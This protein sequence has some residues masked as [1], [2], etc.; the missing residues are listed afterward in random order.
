M[1]TQSIK[2][3]INSIF[4]IF[5]RI[6]GRIYSL[7]SVR[8]NINNIKNNLH[9]IT[10]ISDFS[11]IFSEGANTTVR[12]PKKIL[13]KCCSNLGVKTSRVH[14][15][16]NRSLQK[17]KYFRTNKAITFSQ[18]LKKCNKENYEEAEVILRHINSL[19]FGNRANIIVNKKY[20]VVPNDSLACRNEGKIY[21]FAQGSCVVIGLQTKSNFFLAHYQRHL[22]KEFSD[23]I[24]IKLNNN[25][26]VIAAY[27]ISN[28]IKSDV[29]SLQNICPKIFR[30]NCLRT[31]DKKQS[32]LTNY[33]LK[34]HITAEGP[35]FYKSSISPREFYQYPY[36]R[37]GY[38]MALPFEKQQM[39]FLK[40]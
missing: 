24:R 15:V 36:L 37:Y 8:L 34:I 16:T 21:T 13:K 11:I 7:F 38:E 39:V 2:K 4:N 26:E 14:G 5:N 19:S 20:T 12:I 31:H 32:F 27:I 28:N 35:I 3:N 9:L 22:L 18:L 23:N 29:E 17:D 1:K 33:N 40:Y 10:L 25:I 30:Y 6:I